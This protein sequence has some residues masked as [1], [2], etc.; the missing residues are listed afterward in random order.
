MVLLVEPE[1]SGIPVEN[2]KVAT[3]ELVLE[4]LLLLTLDV[5]VEVE[6]P[7]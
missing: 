3:L 7:V 5:D 2:L 1:S 4:V 6:L